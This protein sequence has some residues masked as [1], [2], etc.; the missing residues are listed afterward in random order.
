MTFGTQVLA[1]TSSEAA[2]AFVEVG[3]IAI[4]L[5]FLALIAS[6]VGITAVPLY[7]MAGL[8]FGDGGFIDVTAS[9]DFVTLTAEIGVLLLLLTLGLE[10][11]ADEL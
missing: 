7:L 4:G 8:A 6:R 3:A 1:A 10:Y 5:S 2:T 11:S 9:S